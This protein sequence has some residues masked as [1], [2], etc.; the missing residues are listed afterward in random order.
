MIEPEKYNLNNYFLGT[1]VESN[2]ND[3]MRKRKRGLSIFIYFK[4]FNPK[5]LKNSRVY[6]SDNPGHIYGKCFITSNILDQDKS[7][8]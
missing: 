6:C 8:F 3:S 2:Q 4:Y 5:Y 1:I 7:G